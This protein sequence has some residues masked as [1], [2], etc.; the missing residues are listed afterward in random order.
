MT[1]PT[2]KPSVLPT[3]SASSTA[4]LPFVG[5][6]V[7]QIVRQV[8]EPAGAQTDGELRVIEGVVEQRRE[9]AR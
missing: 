7:D 1:R 9:L 6:A 2:E 8:H 5:H 4:V 3:V